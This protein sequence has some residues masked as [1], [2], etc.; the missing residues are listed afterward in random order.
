M[1]ELHSGAFTKILLIGIAVGIVAGGAA[2]F[3]TSSAMMNNFA[4]RDMMREFYEVENAVYVSPTE[5][6]QALSTG[7]SIATVVDLRAIA[8]YEAGHLAGAINIPVDQLTD[9]EIIAA[10]SELSTEKPI[11]TYC[12]SSYCM[13]S[14]KVG[15]FLA[16]N[17]IFVKHLTVGGKEINSVYLDYVVKGSEPGSVPITNPNTG[18]PPNSVS[19]FGC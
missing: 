19:G 6:T 18:C 3:I 9:T 17:G 14:R 12:Y 10:F 1:T 15:K 16:Q 5:Y 4:E 2:G 11:I 8:A 13:L 7:K